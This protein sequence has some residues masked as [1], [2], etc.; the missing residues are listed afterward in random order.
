M[1]G[2]DDPRL[3][4]YRPPDHRRSRFGFR[5]PFAAVWG[6]LGTNNTLYL[7]GEHY[8]R[9]KP[10]SHHAAH[11]PPGVTWYADPAGANEI[12]ELR[13]AGFKVHRGK[14]NLRPGIAAVRARLE[15]GALRLLSGRCPNLLA[16][17]GL[18]RYGT[19]AEGLGSETPVDEHNH[20]LAALRYLITG[21]DT[22]W[23]ARARKLSTP[24]QPPSDQPLLLP[25]PPHHDNWCR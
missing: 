20:A 22:R 25:P 18:Y 4:Q 6:T 15:A 3:L 1:Q 8:S 14:N 19:A 10:L 23:M 5:N 11:L 12:A 7:T 24:Y 2:R 9:E 21:L 17:S 13:C 16:E